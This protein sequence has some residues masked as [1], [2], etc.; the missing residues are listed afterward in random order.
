LSLLGRRLDMAELQ[1]R[2]N[3]VLG[4]TLH[5]VFDVGGMK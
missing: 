3:Q 1:G 4:S 5:F 2:V